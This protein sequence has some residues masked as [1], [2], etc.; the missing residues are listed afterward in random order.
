MKMVMEIGF[1]SVAWRALKK[2]AAET[3]DDAHDRA[4]R[5]LETLQMG[6]SEN[7]SEH[8]ARVNITLIKLE[9]YNITT[10]AREIKRIVMNSLT[11]R[12]PNETSCLRWGEILIW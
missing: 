8:F 7:V 6:D 3:E 9:R 2:I 10:S 1:P 5:E 12:F 4:K 11:P